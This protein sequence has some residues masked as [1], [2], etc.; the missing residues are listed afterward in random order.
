MGPDGEEHPRI[1]GAQEL[2][3]QD[4]M[5]IPSSALKQ[6]PGNAERETL[7]LSESV[8]DTNETISI[9][10]TPDQY[11]F[12]KSSQY[13]K[14][15]LDN[16]SSGVSL[17]MQK[18]RDGQIVFNF[19]FKKVDTVK[20]IKPEHVCQMLMI[21]RRSLMHLVKSNK[22]SSYKI[23]GLRRFLLQDILDYLIRSEEVFTS[24]EV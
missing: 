17:D 24:S 18:Q 4:L 14:Y 16:E 5:E 19:Q 13:I 1:I 9:N 12:I 10:L 11:E 8:G 22:L 15:F 21:S 6:S 20:M 2:Q 7:K 23:G 3:E